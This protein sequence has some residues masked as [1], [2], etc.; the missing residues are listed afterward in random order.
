MPARFKSCS[1]MNCV[2]WDTTPSVV[3]PSFALFALLLGHFQL[4]ENAQELKAAI[5]DAPPGVAVEA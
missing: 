1:R 4:R 3:Y 2:V 5:G